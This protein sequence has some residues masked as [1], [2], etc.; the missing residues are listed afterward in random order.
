MFD[1]PPPEI[2]G[3]DLKIQ[4]R[5]FGA[6]RTPEVGGHERFPVDAVGELHNWHKK[7]FSG[8]CHTGRIIC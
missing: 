2:F 1:S 5:D 3:K 7:V 6:E 4:L 8:I